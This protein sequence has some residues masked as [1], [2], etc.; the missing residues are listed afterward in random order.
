MPK[1]RRAEE[2]PP[3][4]HRPLWWWIL[5]IVLPLVMSEI[6]FYM[7]GRWLSMAIFPVIWIGFWLAVAY[8]SGGI[9]RK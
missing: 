3:P 2:S 4:I 7:A 5:I 1:E 6:M 9:F 8:R